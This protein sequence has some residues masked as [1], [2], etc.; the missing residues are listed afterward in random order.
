[1][2]RPTTRYSNNSSRPAACHIGSNNA[3]QEVE[4]NTPPFT[5]QDTNH[6]HIYFFNTTTN[7]QRPTNRDS[8]S[9][10]GNNAQQ[11]EVERNTPPSLYPSR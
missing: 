6:Y 5:I 4:R 10:P 3:Q 11:L 8:N 9:R 1:M 2:Q 7:L